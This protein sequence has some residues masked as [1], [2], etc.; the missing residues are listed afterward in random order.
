MSWK[1]LTIRRYI[2]GLT[3]GSRRWGRWLHLPRGA[4]RDR[5][6][7]GR[8]ATARRYQHGRAT[9][10][11][12]ALC[13]VS[14][15]HQPKVHNKKFTVIVNSSPGVSVM[16]LITGLKHLCHGRHSSRT[17][18][19]EA[20]PEHWRARLSNRRA[21]SRAYSHLHASEKISTAKQ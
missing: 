18:S 2:K 3:D 4:A 19:L 20:Q 15:R 17:R 9:F 21:H 14:M 11:S 6:K 16:I 13:N 1:Y 10:Q 8:G 5:G 7:L 12:R